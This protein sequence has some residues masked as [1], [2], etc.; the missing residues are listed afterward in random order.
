MYYNLKNIDILKSVTVITN[1]IIEERTI[2]DVEEIIYEYKER[3]VSEVIKK[4][5]VGIYKITQDISPCFEGCILTLHC[6]V[7]EEE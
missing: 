7:Y 4:H 2:M 1:E 6:Y 5:P 3:L